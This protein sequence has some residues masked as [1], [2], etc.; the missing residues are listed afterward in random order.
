MSGSRGFIGGIIGFILGI[1]SGLPFMGIIGAVIGSSIGRSLSFQAGA[2]R[3][4]N[5]FQGRPGSQGQQSYGGSLNS[6]QVFFSS[7]FSMLGKLSIADGSIS[8][9]EKQT[10]YN[11]MRTDLRLDPIS[12]QSAM[13]IFNAA[14]RSGDSFESYARKFYQSFAGNAQFTEL[15]LDI[16]LR[17]AAADGKIHR[18]EERL[19]QEAVGIFGYSQTSYDRL[20]SR[21]GFGGSSSA[22]TGSGVS[23]AYGIL[24]CS[25]SDGDDVIRK[26]YRKKVSEFHPDKISAKG[27]PEE[28]T[29]FAN[30]RF[31]EI[32][33][34]WDSIRKERNL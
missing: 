10:I 17:V 20:K 4:Y 6:G 29:K 13:E 31:S 7:V 30:E 3:Q 32:Q 23:G 21:Y 27:L 1:M 2:S 12:Q 14:I 25:P 15:V 33:Q 18:E 8:E 5:F 22:S 24:G 34:A 11:F 28:F 19:I 26:A 9:S 16:L